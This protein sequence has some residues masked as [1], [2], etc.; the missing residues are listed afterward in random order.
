[1]ALPPPQSHIGGTDLVQSHQRGG[2]PRDRYNFSE[3]LN[4]VYLWVGWNPSHVEA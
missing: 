4:Y 1:M 3:L 2:A